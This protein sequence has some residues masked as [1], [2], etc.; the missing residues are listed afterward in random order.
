MDFGIFPLTT[1][2]CHYRLQGH[3]YLL[4]I[5]NLYIIQ[6]WMNSH[7]V[8]LFAAAGQCMGLNGNKMYVQS[9]KET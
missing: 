3:R 1:A 5:F 4:K 8:R 6:P 7:L 2:F 9:N